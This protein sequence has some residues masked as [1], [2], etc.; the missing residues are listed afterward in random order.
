MFSHMMLVQLRYL[1][2]V[3]SWGWLFLVLLGDLE[4][5]L[6]LLIILIIMG[7]GI[8]LLLVLLVRLLFGLCFRC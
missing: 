7:I 6:I 4:D 3:G 2:L 5:K 1:C 8:V